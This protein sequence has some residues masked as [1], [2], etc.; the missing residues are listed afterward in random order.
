M[1]RNQVS[2]SN[3]ALQ[4]LGAARIVS[5]TEDSV[6]ARHVNACFEEV[7]K[8]ELRDHSWNFSILRAVLAPS[9]TTPTANVDLS[10]NYA[11]PLP[12]GCL[13]ILPPSRRN[14]DWQIESIDNVSAIFSNDG[15][16]I[17][18]RYVAYIEDPTRWDA[19]FAEAVSCRI[20]VQLC[21]AI[22]QSNTKQEKCEREYVFAIRRAK[23][24]NAFENV[25]A[26]EPEDNWI[27]V[28]RPGAL[29]SRNWLVGG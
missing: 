8:Q 5:M 23:R 24:A 13:R 11:F 15:T 4:K 29:G 26:E 6:N 20:A 7:V 28:R 18:L 1:A 12:T 27:A 3:M 25:S 16:S 19:L 21:E 14:L 10:F 2:V 9:A 17:D 22:T